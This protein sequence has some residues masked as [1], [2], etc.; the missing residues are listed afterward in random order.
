MNSNKHLKN[1]SKVAIANIASASL[2]AIF[3]L[4]FA[5]VLP[6]EDYGWISYS[7]GVA[8]TVSVFSRFGLPQT[9]AIYKAKNKL[10][11]TN[12]ANILAVVA[13]IA[14]GIILMPFEFYAGLLAMGLS[15]FVINLHNLL[16][17][18]N[19]NDYAKRALLK[20]SLIVILPFSF[21][22]AFG[23]EGIIFGMAVGNLIASY[24]LFKKINIHA[25]NFRKLKNSFSFILHN[26]T[27]DAST[28]LWRTLD[29]LIMLPIVGFA[30]LGIYQLN[31]QIVL[32][33]AILPTAFY[34]FLL[35]EES[36]G[37]IKKRTYYYQFLITVSLMIAGI[38]LAPVFITNFFPKFSD[39]IFAL[40]IIMIVLLPMSI[41][42]ILNAKLQAM[43][44]TKVGFSAITKIVILIILLILL[45][46]MF[47]IVGLSLAIVISTFAESGVLLV[48]YKKM[49]NQK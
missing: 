49:K 12:N 48:F 7:I 21:Y 11:L 39:G 22:Y 1:Y 5:S 10:E 24:D 19:Y 35:S 25:K 41:N 43:E 33:A 2:Q 28:D 34:S 16:G 27:L 46:N 18:K 47:S 6:L 26:F 30:T 38:I 15:L 3:Y 37:T 36:Q 32:I 17:E 9:I 31:L 20:G 23:F 42:S 29:K 40:Q 4:Y 13:S 14:A 8:G 44:S 45:G